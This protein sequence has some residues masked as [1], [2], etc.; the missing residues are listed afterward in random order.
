MKSTL[1]IQNLK[2]SGCSTTIIERLSELNTINN[3]S[4]NQK[5]DT[6]NIEH[7]A[8]E[9][10]E[11]AKNLLSKLGYPLYG[12]NNSLGRKLKSYLSCTSG[13]IH[14]KLN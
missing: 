4:V 11:E 13:R 5:Y 8:K 10:V 12:E 1:Y 7:T 14:H 2:C 9:N 3:I 6:V